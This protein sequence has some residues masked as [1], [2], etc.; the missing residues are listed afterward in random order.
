MN[1]QTPPRQEYLTKT[2][3]RGSVTV[4]LHQPILDEK[5]RHRREGIVLTALANFGKS[6]KAINT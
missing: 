4:V 3:K 1:N 2:I 5:E 6:Q